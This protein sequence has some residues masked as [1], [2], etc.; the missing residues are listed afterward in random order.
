M[1]PNW[2]YISPPL[3]SPPL[4]AVHALPRFCSL[5]PPFSRARSQGAKSSDK[6]PRECRGARGILKNAALLEGGKARGARAWR[7]PAR[8]AATALEGINL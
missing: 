4:P 1:Q 7:R 6:A 3:S 8:D 2:L 5:Q